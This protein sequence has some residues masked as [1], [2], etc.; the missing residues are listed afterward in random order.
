MGRRG[1]KIVKGRVEWRKQNEVKKIHIVMTVI[2]IFLSL[3]IAA[4]AILAWIQ[5]KQATAMSRAVSSAIPSSAPASSES[6]VLPVYDDSLNLLLVGASNRLPD[7]W[8]PQLTDYGSVK[9]D[10][11]IVP[12]LRA[13]MEAAQAEGCPLVLTEGYVDS[14]TQEKRFRDEAARIMAKEKLSEVRADDKAQATVG[15]GGCSESQTGLAVDFSAPD[16][17]NGGNFADTVQY[18]WLER[19]SV[20]YGFI[21]RYPKDASAS[22]GINRKTG[23]TFRPT[24]FRY[25]GTAHAMKMREYSMCLEEYIAYLAKRG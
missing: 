21:L 2:A 15:R 10:A 16:L 12:A 9:V 25:V 11:R 18:R 17:K 20:D 8:K 7:T 4:G 1:E 6:G 5:V 13:M 23:C 24:H 14:D 22:D 19:N 3:S